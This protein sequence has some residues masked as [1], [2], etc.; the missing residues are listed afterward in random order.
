MSES[1]NT[2]MLTMLG[3]GALLWLLVD[4]HRAKKDAQDARD[5]LA[6]ADL[7]VRVE[8]ASTPQV[9]PA[10]AP[11][12]RPP[13]GRSD[14]ARLAPRTFDAVFALHGRGLPVPYLRALALHESDMNPR[15]TMSTSSAAGLLQVID[16]VRSGFNARHGTA[17]ERRDLFD[18][19]INVTIASDLLARIAAAYER[20]HPEVPNLRT[21]WSN[22][23]FVE[24]LTFGWN[25]GFSERAG[26]GLVASTLVARRQRD[27][28]IDDIHRAAKAA[29]AS[30]HL[31][32]ARK[33]RWAKAVTAQYLRE[34][35]RDEADG[36]EA[37]APVASVVSAAV[38]PD[39]GPVTAPAQVESSEAAA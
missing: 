10:A 4:R 29:G 13:P 37:P 18:P 36:Y 39:A 28:T 34:R 38:A 30:A 3:G 5:E 22:P 35:A 6:L 16:V 8:A 20:Y 1:T 32:N 15:A 9:R 25:A 12:S 33:V 31:S 17:Y 27:L 2:T 19:A 26:V 11:P 7:G 23:R 21:D 24:L 14:L